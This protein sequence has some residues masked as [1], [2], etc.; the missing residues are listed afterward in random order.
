MLLSMKA[1]IEPM[2]AALQGSSSSN[3]E[4]GRITKAYEQSLDRLEETAQWLL[5]NRDNE[6]VVLGAIA[7]DFMMLAGYV[8]G[9]WQLTRSALVA[10]TRLIEGAGNDVF[11]QQKIATSLFYAQ[12]ILPRVETHAI[13]VLHGGCSMTKFESL[14]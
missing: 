5:D 12:H 2:R 9:A 7:F 3:T 6:D 8:M 10:D 1:G 4:I 11:Y 13:I 14:V